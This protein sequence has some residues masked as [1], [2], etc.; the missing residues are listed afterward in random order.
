MDSNAQHDDPLTVGEW[1][2]ETRRILHAARNGQ[3]YTEGDFNSLVQHRL[4]G[5]WLKV[6][7]CSVDPLTAEPP[8]YEKWW[9]LIEAAYVN[10]RSPPGLILVAKKQVREL[11]SGELVIPTQIPYG[12]E[13]MLVMS[14]SFMPIIA[15]DPEQIAWLVLMTGNQGREY[16]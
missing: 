1:L 6:D 8:V 11:F 9:C 10:K 5:H 4:Q 7:G 2:D 15:T 13:H 14:S 16:G 3:F 12:Q